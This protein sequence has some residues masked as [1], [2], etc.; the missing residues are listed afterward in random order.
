MPRNVEACSS[1]GLKCIGLFIECLEMCRPVVPMLA[2]SGM[3]RLPLA[4][5]ESNPSID[6]CIETISIIPFVQ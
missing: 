1:I 6:R 3:N 2:L 5:P 4:L